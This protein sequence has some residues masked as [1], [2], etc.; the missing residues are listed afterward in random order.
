M[1]DQ[2]RGKH[3]GFVD[4]EPNGYLPIT[5]TLKNASPEVKQGVENSLLI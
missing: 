5:R 3:E 2:W 4:D 1:T